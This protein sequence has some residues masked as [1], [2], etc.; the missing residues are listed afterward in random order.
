MFRCHFQEPSASCFQITTY[1]TGDFRSTALSLKRQLS[2]A[3][4]VGRISQHFGFDRG[5]KRIAQ[6]TVKTRTAERTAWYAPA[7]LPE[8]PRR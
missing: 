6:S 5:E 4:L 8:T 1:L 2:A 7:P 3:D